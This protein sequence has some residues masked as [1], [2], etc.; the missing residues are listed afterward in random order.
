METVMEGWYENQPPIAKELPRMQPLAN[1]EHDWKLLQRKFA[2]GA[3]VVQKLEYLKE[4]LDKP[5][6]KTDG[7]KNLALIEA[8]DVAYDLDKWLLYLEEE[9]DE[10]A[11]VRPPVSMQEQQEWLE[12]DIATA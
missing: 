6:D 2:A 11:A 3:K 10:F 12:N 5:W 8:D 9:D 1:P 7:Q 4:F